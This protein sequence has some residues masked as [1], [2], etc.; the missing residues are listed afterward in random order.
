MG[1]HEANKYLHHRINREEIENGIDN[2]FNIII[3]EN[4]HRLSTVCQHISPPTVF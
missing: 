2:L 3:A 1:H 4:F